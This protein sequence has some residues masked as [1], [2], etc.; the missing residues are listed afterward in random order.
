[1]K[2]LGLEP[3]NW[4]IR[5]TVSQAERDVHDSCKGPLCCTLD[6]LGLAPFETVEV[7]SGTRNLEAEATASEAEHNA[8]L[9]HESSSSSSFMVLY[10]LRNHKTYQGRGK[11]GGRSGRDDRT[12]R[13]RAPTR[14]D[15]LK[16]P[17]AIARTTMLRRWGPRQCEATCV[18]RQLLFQQ[19]C[20][21]VSQ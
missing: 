3:G 10:V 2:G 16:R 19:L 1:M 12:A 17:L 6:R 18:L 5:Q 11:G 21:T 13:P 15:R 20:G 4:K 9:H 7:K 14:K 8:L